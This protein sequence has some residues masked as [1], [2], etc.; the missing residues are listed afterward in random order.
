MVIT[1]TTETAC[2]AVNELLQGLTAFQGENGMKA[3]RI[4]RFDISEDR[5]NTCLP[6]SGCQLC[7]CQDNWGRA[8]IIPFLDRVG[9]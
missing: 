9:S 2:M 8:D 7:A 4:R 5:A 6:V 1:F 3:G